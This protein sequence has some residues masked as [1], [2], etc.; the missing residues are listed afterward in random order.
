MQKVTLYCFARQIL[1]LYFPIYC[2]SQRK[3]FSDLFDCSACDILQVAA[4]LEIFCLKA[5][6]TTRPITLYTFKSAEHMSRSRCFVLLK[7]TS[8]VDFN[9][10]TS[11]FCSFQKLFLIH[12]P[13]L[14]F[15]CTQK[16]YF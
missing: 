16:V 8:Y 5:V 2:F 13:F 11:L 14:F 6:Y 1:Y 3:E 15:Q 10:I 12:F 4:F 9:F 7:F